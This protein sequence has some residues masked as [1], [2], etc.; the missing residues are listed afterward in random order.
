MIPLKCIITSE[1]NIALY[2]ICWY[3]QL[4]WDLC[5]TA[6]MYYVHFMLSQKKFTKKILISSPYRRIRQPVFSNKRFINNTNNK[7]PKFDT[8]GTLEARIKSSET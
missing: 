3:L 8:Y 5:V 6:L 1:R 7:N 4:V 2:Y